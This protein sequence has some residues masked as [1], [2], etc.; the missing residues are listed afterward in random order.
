[1]SSF[2]IQ[3]EK[4]YDA[5]S[6]A[7]FQAALGAVGG[8]E[9][10]ILKQDAT[11]GTIEAEFHKTILGKVLGDRTHMNVSISGAAGGTAVAIEIYPL[12]AVGQKLMFGA[13][14]GVSRTVANWFFAHLE[15]RLSP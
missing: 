11:A 13:R 1:M 14:K 5:S 7:I 3:D 10:K 2:T 4:Q 12:N 9:G 6:E 15:H 8:L